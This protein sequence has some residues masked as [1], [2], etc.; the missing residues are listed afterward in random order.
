MPVSTNIKKLRESHGLSQVEFG[1][2]FGVSDKAVSSWESGSREPKMGTVQKIARHFRVPISAIT[3]DE[4]KPFDIFSIPN[5]IPLPQTTMVPII[6]SIACGTPITAEVNIEGW[7]A[8]PDGKRADFA[9]RCK[10]DSMINA[11][12]YDGDVVYIREQPSV[13][14]GEIAA[15]QIDGEATLK[16]VYIKKN[17]IT[18]MAENSTYDPMTFTPD[19]CD[20][21]RILGK[22]VA[23]LSAVR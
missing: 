20:D 1:R 9:L 23:F 4:H 11:R 10:G 8:L 21:I 17:V 22:A 13:E 2:L 16:R 15:V 12:I 7:L 18:L 19:N 6:G 14:N 5:V 3:D